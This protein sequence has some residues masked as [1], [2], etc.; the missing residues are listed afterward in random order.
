MEQEV[1]AAFLREQAAKCRR[2][3]EGI[4][5]QLAV[6]ALRKLAEDFELRAAASVASSDSGTA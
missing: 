3:A 5:D 1:E 4:E 2:L 6:T